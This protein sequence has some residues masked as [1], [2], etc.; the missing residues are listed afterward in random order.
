MMPTLQPWLTALLIAF[1]R[2]G[3]CVAPTCAVPGIEGPFRESWWREVWTLDSFPSSYVTGCMCPLWVISF[4]VSELQFLYL[5][6]MG[7]QDARE[8]ALSVKCFPCKHEDLSL[9][10][11]NHVKEAGHVW[12]CTLVIP[13]QKSVGSWGSLTGPDSLLSS[14]SVTGSALKLK[15]ITPEK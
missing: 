12:W 13:M 5:Q 2:L 9:I 1:W 14:G 11:R 3:L 8:M 7:Q 15:W 4:G 10:L 6:K